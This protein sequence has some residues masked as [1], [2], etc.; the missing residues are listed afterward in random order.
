ML[1]LAY[2]HALYSLAPVCL[3]ATLSCDDFMDVTMGDE[4]SGD[5]AHV[6][7]LKE[8][9]PMVTRPELYSPYWR[10]I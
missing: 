3:S 2:I 10:H 6:L 5:I 9:F 4:P 1:Y 7:P 8:Y